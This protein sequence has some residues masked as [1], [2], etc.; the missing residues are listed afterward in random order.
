[1]LFFSS[2]EDQTMNCWIMIQTDVPPPLCSSNHGSDNKTAVHERLYR[3]ACAFLRMNFKTVQIVKFII[4]KS[5]VHIKT[6]HCNKTV[7]ISNIPKH[8]SSYHGSH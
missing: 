7:L 8:L 1:M 4:K 5:S 2:V 3:F 6:D